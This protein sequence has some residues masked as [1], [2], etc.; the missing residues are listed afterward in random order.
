MRGWG[1]RC[2]SGRRGR[3]RGVG[4]EDDGLRYLFVIP[5]LLCFGGRAH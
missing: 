5:G 3:L 1:R 4:I 2:G